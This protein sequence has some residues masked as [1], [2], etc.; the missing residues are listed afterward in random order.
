MVLENITI[1]SSLILPS[2]LLHS[3]FVKRE[4]SWIELHGALKPNS[5]NTFLA[6]G[7]S[8][9]R[10]A[11]GCHGYPLLGK[12]RPTL[13]R[14]TTAPETSGGTSDDLQN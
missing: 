11:S 6:T 8:I 2:D 14:E 1:S 5:A 4:L 10:P 7:R 3:V 13:D 9:A 12:S